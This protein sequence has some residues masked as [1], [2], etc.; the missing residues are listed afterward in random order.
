MT[1]PVGLESLIVRQEGFP[2]FSRE[3]MRA[4]QLE[5]LNFQL[6]RAKSRSPFYRDYPDALTSLEELKSLPF[7]SA[8]DI[9]QHFSQLCLVHPDE[10][11]RLRTASTSGTSGA[12]KRIAYSQ[13]DCMRTLD[14][15]ECGLGELIFPGDRVLICMPFTDSLSL[16][17]LIAQAVERLGA[18]PVAAGAEK[19]FGQYIDLCKRESTNVYIGSPVLLLSI[20]RMSKC[21]L[22][23]RRALV[24]GDHCADSVRTAA[25]RALGSRLFPHYGLRESGLGCALT[26]S[27]HE[28][29]HVRENDV[30]CEIISQNGAPLPPM[31]WGE[32]VITTIGMDA[33]P[34]FR[35]R[36]GDFARVLSGVCPCGSEVLRIEVTERIQRGMDIGFF[37]ELLFAFD[38]IV[39][40]SIS[41]QKAVISVTEESADLCGSVRRLLRG[42]SVGFRQARLTDLPMYPGKRRIL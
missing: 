26:C 34:L 22:P 6:H 21:V 17:G 25:E 30:I 27:A 39:D 19:S 1:N 13:Y 8:D 20:L 7:T 40:F 24:S 35:Y 33:M 18:V 31:Q 15:F 5:L 42:F 11:A 9:R 10:F 32:L 29:L 23:L 37:D 12:P 28:G 16:G 2:F 4:R 41:G 36:T 3:L 14:F 38:E